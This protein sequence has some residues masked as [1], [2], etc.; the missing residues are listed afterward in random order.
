MRFQQR[1][2]HQANKF[3]C[4]ETEFAQSRKE[5]FREGKLNFVR[6]IDCRWEL[7]RLWRRHDRAPGR[8]TESAAGRDWVHWQ[9]NVRPL[10]HS[11][12]DALP[13]RPV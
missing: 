11:R 4:K 7:H 8:G 9:K 13:S 12:A 5:K 1:S 3:P 6:T 10:H 2:A